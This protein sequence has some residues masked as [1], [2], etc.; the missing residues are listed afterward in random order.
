[1][2]VGWVFL[3]QPFGQCVENGLREVRAR[4]A[5]SGP[6]A[7]AG[8]GGQARAAAVGD[9]MVRSVGVPDSF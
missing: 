5:W 6:P 7:G 3:K 4:Q 2:R 9:S 1:M 8:R